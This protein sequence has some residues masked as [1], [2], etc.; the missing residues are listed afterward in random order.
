MR[1][2]KVP[3]I[4]ELKQIFQKNTYPYIEGPECPEGSK[5]PENC[6]SFLVKFRDIHIGP[7]RPKGPKIQTNF[8]KNR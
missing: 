5:G 2:P 7:K 4:P 3:K 8:L 6:S 1:S